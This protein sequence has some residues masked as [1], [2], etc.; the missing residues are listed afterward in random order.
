MDYGYIEYFKKAMNHPKCGR[1]QLIFMQVKFHE[2]QRDYYV[3]GLK[4]INHLIH[5]DEKPNY[6][7][8]E[9]KWELYK[10]SISFEQISKS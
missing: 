2:G 5:I 4:P 1:K 6:N 3:P 8:T 7:I 10:V 9:S